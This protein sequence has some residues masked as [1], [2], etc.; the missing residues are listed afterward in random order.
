[1]IKLILVD[2]VDDEEVVEL[3]Q[4]LTMRDLKKRKELFTHLDRYCFID[5]HFIDLHWLWQIFNSTN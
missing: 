4:R 5:H 2:L 3:L 1:V